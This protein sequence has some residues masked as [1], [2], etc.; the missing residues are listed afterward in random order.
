MDG[1]TDDQVNPQ[2]I[3]PGQ[4]NVQAQPPQGNPQQIQF[5]ML[6]N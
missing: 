4:L 5:E 6:M 3:Q 2:Y 1:S